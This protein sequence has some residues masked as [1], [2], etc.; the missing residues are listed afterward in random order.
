M[1]RS[2]T[3]TETDMAA[4]KSLPVS[5]HPLFP[6]MVGL[7]F[8]ALFGIGMM[9]LPASLIGTSDRVLPAVALALLGGTIGCAI[10]A[11]IGRKH[12]LAFSD[13]EDAGSSAFAA[14]QQLAR[15]KPISALE[16]L[17]EPMVETPEGEDV[18]AEEVPVAEADEADDTPAEPE[19]AEF[20]PAE[21]LRESDD[22][23]IE[24]KPDFERVDFGLSTETEE[25]VEEVMNQPVEEPVAEEEEPMVFSPPSLARPVEQAEPQEVQ[26]V[27]AIARADIATAPL[28]DLDIFELGLRLQMSVERL[29]E[30]AARHQVD[31]DAAEPAEAQEIRANFGID[32]EQ[33]EDS[34]A[35]AAL[36]AFFDDVDTSPVETQEAPEVEEIESGPTNAP[37]LH[38]LAPEFEHPAE[39]IDFSDG[40]NIDLSLPL[41]HFADLDDLPD[42]KLELVNWQDRELLASDASDDEFDADKDVEDDIEDE[43]GD[44]F[45]SLLDM[46]PG[47]AASV[48]PI[49]FSEPQNSGAFSQPEPGI[50]ANMADVQSLRSIREAHPAP[51][52]GRR[53]IDP[54]E[55]DR[56]LRGALESLRRVNGAA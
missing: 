1:A 55:T 39:E 56:S 13:E 53:A 52:M 17:G 46:K 23:M 49:G 20:Q 4:A 28:D 6:L 21:T 10:A 40:F 32:A 8:A 15:P 51:T 25:A 5:A 35:S 18:E 37:G 48:E 38:P 9:I 33:A 50:A 44:N 42:D 3:D 34:E 27:S 24:E 45:S 7:W 43:A 16:E 2:G 41:S 36:A 26:Q 12:Q 31:K 11:R 54:A 30:N 47:S 29:R 19:T 22:T 14:V